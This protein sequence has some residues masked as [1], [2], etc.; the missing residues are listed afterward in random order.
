MSKASYEYL[1][2]EYEV[3]D[4]RGFERDQFLSDNAIETFL[5]VGKKKKP[6]SGGDAAAATG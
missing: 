1:R 2:D 4:G 5:I 3:E 6:S